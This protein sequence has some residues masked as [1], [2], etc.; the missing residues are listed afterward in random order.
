MAHYRFKGKSAEE[1]FEI[2]YSENH[3]HDEESKSGTGSNKNNTEAVIGIVHDVI[4]ELG[5]KSMLDIP[6]GDFNWMKD[7]DLT[8]VDYLGADI[9]TDIIVR[10]NQQY[11]SDKVRFEN[12]NLFKSFLPNVDLIFSRD[13]LVHFS[14]DDIKRSIEAVKRSGSVYWM[15][16]TFPNHTNYDII[17]G[18]WRPINLQTEPFNFPTPLYIFKELCSEDHRY[19]DKSLA[20]WRIIDL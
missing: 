13:C 10:N 14:Y 4:N 7:V 11:A 6:C 16:T 20:V 2:I 18:D 9:V 5:I 19:S 12:L 15:T 1:I 17:T 3:W 8:G